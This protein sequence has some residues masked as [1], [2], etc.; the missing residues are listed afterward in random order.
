MP[1][2]PSDLLHGTLDVLI[3]KALTL[4][5]LHGYAVSRWIEERTG[6]LLAV[7]DA[8]LYKAL[9]RLEAQQAIASDWGVSET[10]RKAKYYQLTSRGRRLL[11][12]EAKVWEQ[13]AGAVSAV[14][15]TAER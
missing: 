8:A 9:H 5:P 3:L 10:N 11:R 12:T 2:H 13:Y 15:H 6:G 14:L 1:K 4:G 7:E